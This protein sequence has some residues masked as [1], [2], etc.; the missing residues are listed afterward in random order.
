MSS[1]TFKDTFPC[2]SFPSKCSWRTRWHSP[3]NPLLLLAANPKAVLT[4]SV[5]F[6]SACP[7]GSASNST[8]LNGTLGKGKS[9]PDTQHTS[10]PSNRA[11]SVL[12]SSPAASATNLHWGLL[13]VKWR[14]C[15][16][17]VMLFSDRPLL[18]SP[19]CTDNYVKS[20]LKTVCQEGRGC[21]G[22]PEW[23][24]GRPAVTGYLI[25]EN[26]ILHQRNCT[27]LQVRCS[28]R[29]TSANGRVSNT[30]K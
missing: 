26:G 17:D 19:V 30:D 10:T 13:Q 25:Q 7:R 9:S 2:Q 29:S 22:N 12:A 4:C 18:H 11:D 1:L 21:K 3:R 20:I 28:G 24:K 23:F 5:P 14:Q 16:G 15:Q 27:P 8:E 6:L